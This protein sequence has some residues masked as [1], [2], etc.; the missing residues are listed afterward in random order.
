MVP[1]L[2]TTVIH[3]PEGEEAVRIWYPV[4]TVPPSEPGAVQFRVIES[5]PGEVVSPVGAVAVACGV[6]VADAGVPALGEE[7]GVTWK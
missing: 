7:I 1:V 4:S 5:A 2:V 3:G 6:A